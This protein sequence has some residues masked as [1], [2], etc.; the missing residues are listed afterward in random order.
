MSRGGPSGQVHDRAAR[1]RRGPVPARRPARACRAAPARA[2]SRGRARARAV[3]S[4]ARVELPQR[5]GL[6]PIPEPPPAH[7]PARVRPAPADRQRAGAARPGHHPRAV[8]AAPL[9]GPARARAG[10]PVRAAREAL[11]LRHAGRGAGAGHVRAVLTRPS[12]QGELDR[13]ALARA[14]A[15]DCGAARTRE[16]GRRGPGRPAGGVT[17]RAESLAR[18]PGLRLRAPL[19]RARGPGYRLPRGHALG[20]ALAIDRVVGRRLR[21]RGPPGDRCRSG[22]RDLRPLRD[23]EPARLLPA[24]ERA[25]LAHGRPHAVRRGPEPDVRLLDPA[26]VGRRRHSPVHLRR[27]RGHGSADP[28]RPRGRDRQHSRRGERPALR[29]RD[30]RLR[31]GRALGHEAEECR[32]LEHRG[33]RGLELAHAAELANAVGGTLVEAELFRLG[34]LGLAE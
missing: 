2:V 5:L 18:T 24:A 22:D 4:G 1:G 23:L 30:L 11:A 21:A 14:P 7:G 13:A 29:A 28:L 27:A 26:R 16:P 33:L 3:L 17:H 34:C 12:A 6:V 20:A 10:Q 15:R 9:G 8:R 25:A 31:A 32:G 19:G